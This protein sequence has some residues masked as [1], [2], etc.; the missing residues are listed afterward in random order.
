AEDGIRYATV[1]GVQTCALPICIVRPASCWWLRLR[2]EPIQLLEICGFREVIVE[3][4]LGRTLLV[5]GGSI[6]RERD[7]QAL[8]CAGQLAKDAGEV[9]PAHARKANVHYEDLGVFLGR[10]TECLLTIGGGQ[11]GEPHPFQ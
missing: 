8:L 3:A 5:L 4:R 1:T 10:E 11:N 2:H 6:P 9:V 7:Q